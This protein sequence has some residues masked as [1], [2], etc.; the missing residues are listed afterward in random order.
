MPGWTDLL[1]VLVELLPPGSIT[2]YA[3]VSEWG[4]G[5]RNRNHPV[6]ALLLGMSNHGHGELTNRMVGVNGELAD[7]PEGPE[8]QSE[9]LAA[10]GVPFTDDGRVD[11]TQIAPAEL[12]RFEE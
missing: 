1:P 10:E 2:T 3:E 4:Y 9:Q 12:P 8:Q 7:I 6:R 5:V 11:L